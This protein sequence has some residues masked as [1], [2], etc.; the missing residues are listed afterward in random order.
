MQ[1]GEADAQRS[2]LAAQQAVTELRGQLD[3]A[4]LDNQRLQERIGKLKSKHARQLEQLQIRQ[5]YVCCC[6]ATQPVGCALTSVFVWQTG[7]VHR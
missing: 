6:M 7:A 1:R 3:Q 4:V 2:V 5:K